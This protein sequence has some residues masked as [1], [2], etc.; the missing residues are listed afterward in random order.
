MSPIPGFMNWLRMKLSFLCSRDEGAAKFRDETLLTE[1]EKQQI[2]AFGRGRFSSNQD[3][4]NPY[5]IF[6]SLLDMFIKDPHGVAEE[7]DPV[8]KPILM[9]LAARYL[10]QEKKRSRALDDVANFHVRNGAICHRLNWKADTQ[11]LRLKESAG[12]MV[13]YLYELENVERNAS[14]YATK[15]TIPLGLEMKE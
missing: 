12:L 7:L 8:L 10:V 5:I 9:R 2:T 15:G 11:P 4:D 14:G 13:N 3:Q 1:A 6:I